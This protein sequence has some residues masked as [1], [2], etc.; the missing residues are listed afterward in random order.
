MTNPA[1]KVKS[2]GKSSYRRSKKR[3]MERE[4]KRLRNIIPGLRNRRDIDEADVIYASIAYMNQLEI[5]LVNRKCDG[6]FSQIDHLVGKPVPRNLLQIS[7]RGE[8]LIIPPVQSSEVS[9]C[10][11]SDDESR[12]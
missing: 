10:L 5:A 12:N 8:T 2:N 6:D 3:E 11:T 9:P 7:S 4:I 1:L